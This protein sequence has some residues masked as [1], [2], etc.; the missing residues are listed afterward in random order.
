MTQARYAFFDL[1][2]TLISEASMISFL[3]HYFQSTQPD[4]AAAVWASFEAKAAGMRAQHSR[5]ALNAWY[6]RQYFSD[7]PVATI[8]RIAREWLAQRSASARFFK[9]HALQHLAMHK[10]AG[11]RVV[12]LT[13]SFREV[14]APLTVLLGADDFICAPL[15]EIDGAYT[16]RLTAAPTIGEGKVAALQRYLDTHGVQAADCYGYGDDDSDLPFLHY[17]GHPGVVADAKPAL[18]AHAQ[19]LGWELI[20]PRATAKDAALA[21]V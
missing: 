10:A 12:L 11:T 3:R 7:M 5:E 6:Y 18:V 2:G 16:G 17:V 1:D 8:D 21:M 19:A 13:G 15:E 9:P 4:D 14:V 20:G